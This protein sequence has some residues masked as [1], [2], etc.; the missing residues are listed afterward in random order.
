LSGGNDASLAG[1]LAAPPS[2]DLVG[3]PSHVPGDPYKQIYYRTTSFDNPYWIADNN[4]FNEETNRFFGNGYAEFMTS[5]GGS[6]SLQV[7]YQLGV[8][9]Y[10]SHYQDVFGYGSY[11]SSNNVGSIDNYGVT[12]TTVNSLLTA[13]YDWKISGDMDFGFIAGNEFDH[14]N[15]KDYEEYGESFNF[16]GWNHISNAKTVTAYENKYKD[17]TVGFFYSASWSWKDM[18]YLNTTGRNDIVSSMPRGN[19]SFFYPS[20]SLGVVISEL[21]GIKEISWLDFAKIRGSYAEV[22]QAGEYVANFYGTPS[23][24]GGFWKGTPVSYPMDG[25]SAYTPYKILYDPGLKP[26]NTKSYEIGVNLK[27]FKGR[28]SFDYTFSKQNVKDQIFNVPLAGS[29]GVNEL[30]MN[31]GAIS[32]DS[33]EFMVGLIPVKTSNFMWDIGVNFS[34]VDNVVDELAEGVESIFLGGFVTPQVRAGIG[35][36]Y[37]VIY[38]TAFK[39]N[40]AGQIL[41]D[42][43]PSSSTY[44]MPMAGKNEVIGSVSPDFILGWNTSFTFKNISLAGVFEWKNGGEM[45]SGSNGLMDLYGVSE[46]TEDREST[47]LYDGYKTDG[48]PND[49]VRGGS[50]DKKAYQTLYYDVLGN[51]DEYYIH[52]NSFIKLRELSLGYQFPKKVLLDMDIFLNVFARNI[53]IWTE[54]DNLDP[55]C[56]QGNTNMMGS[57]ERFSMPQTTSYGFGVQVKF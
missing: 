18:V 12:E 16:G 24:G 15:S 33:H 52:G 19:R 11:R 5:L 43:D 8:D 9:T 55:E 22:G 46:R 36:T 57:F 17:R 41:V 56:S 7:K 10:T 29:S 31:G 3:I 39:R 49:I 45:Y 2:Y 13:N 32:T 20:V 14:T 35:Y 51:V 44:G 34:K 53:L 30:K 37:P 42:E 54:L 21:Q 27:M 40:D 4:T 25:V 28:F 48:T 38:G 26:Q 23:Y 47:F 1:V 6:M 50:N